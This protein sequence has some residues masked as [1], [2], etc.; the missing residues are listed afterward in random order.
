MMNVNYFD[1]IHAKIQQATL[2]IR[3]TD[4]VLI[5]EGVNKTFLSKN[6]SIEEPFFNAPCFISFPDGSH[7]EVNDLESRRE[8]LT[9]LGYKK[10]LVERWQ[11]QWLASLIAILAMAGILFAAHHWAMPWI[12]DKVAVVVPDELEKKLGAQIIVALDDSILQPSKLSDKTIS[13]ADQLFRRL[14]PKDSRLPIHL[15]VRFSKQI[16][17]NAFALPGG[18]VVVTDQMMDLI[19]GVSGNDISGALAGELSGVFAHEIGHIEKRHAMRGLIN[20]SFITVVMGTLFG[21]FSGVAAFAPTILLRT[22]YFRAMES[23]AD[24]YAI[25]LLKANNISPNHVANLFEFLSEENQ[26]KRKVNLPTWLEKV[27]S[28]TA[29]HPPTRERMARFRQAVE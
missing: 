26:R 22:E 18:T 8:L 16:G 5:G 24:E 21:D 11:D 20:D 19:V 6:I 7:C 15:E 13:Q 3:A 2:A 1:G 23:E 17:A 14:V 10:S 9:Q 27:S 29:T 4:V 12:S 28:Y 25:Q